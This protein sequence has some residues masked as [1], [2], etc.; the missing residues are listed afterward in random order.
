MSMLKKHC[1]YSEIGLDKRCHSWS[2]SRGIGLKHK[3]IAWFKPKQIMWLVYE[4]TE[5]KD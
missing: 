5:P 1:R 2:K 3:Q 4:D